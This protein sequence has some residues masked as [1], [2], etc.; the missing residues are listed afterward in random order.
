MFTLYRYFGHLL[1]MF[2][3]LI[4]LLFAYDYYLY[5]YAVC[6]HCFGY[7]VVCSRII[8]AGDKS[9]VQRMVQMAWTFINDRSGL[10]FVIDRSRLIQV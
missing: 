6:L 3:L 4:K 8:I 5:S 2:T 9:K 1:E 7:N 10:Q